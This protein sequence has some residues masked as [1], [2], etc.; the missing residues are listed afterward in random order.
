VKEPQRSAAPAAQPTPAARPQAGEAAPRRPGLL[1]I[2]S[3]G[4]LMSV[5]ADML[6][7]LFPILATEY[8]GLTPAQTGM[9]YLAASLVT[10]GAGPLFRWLA[11]HL[12]RERVRLLHSA[13]NVL[14]SAL[15]LASPTFLG[16][17][18]ARVTDDMSKAA[19]RP[20]RGALGDSATSDEPATQSGPMAI[21]G[22]GANVGELLAPI[23]AGILLTSGG[24]LALM[25]TRIA[26][27]ACTEVYAVYI[28]RRL[29]AAEDAPAPAGPPTGTPV[30]PLPIQ[31]RPAAP[32]NAGD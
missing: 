12:N 7:G 24:L 26:L 29:Q 14:S 25:L 5:T 15:Y 2:A 3:L 27:A 21:L 28:T 31:V 6:R 23:L 16:V 22:V 30:Q 19:F 17:A 4:A 11:G 9:I 10:L 18:T 20:A 1:P 32:G 13:A 8:A